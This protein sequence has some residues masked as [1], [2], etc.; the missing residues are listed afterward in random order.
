M[1]QQDV[2]VGGVYAAKITDKVVP[3]RIDA[4]NANGGWDGTNLTT[5]KKVRIKSARKLRGP[6]TDPESAKDATTATTTPARAKKKTRTTGKAKSATA[7]TGAKR[8]ADEPERMTLMDAAVQ[9][10]REAGEPLRVKQM[11][12]GIWDQKL[13][14]GDGMTPSATLSAAILR[15]LRKGKDARFKKVDRGLFALNEEAEEDGE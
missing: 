12:R 9:V 7:A 14:S 15:D 6:A 5:N 4:E 13:W 10:C 8:G 3:V 11:M 1:K 2:K